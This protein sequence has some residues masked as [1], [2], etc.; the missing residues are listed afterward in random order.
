MLISAVLDPS[1]FD[2]DYFDALYRIH[3]E[4][5]LKGIERNGLLI[6]DLEDILENEISERIY[7]APTEYGQQLQ[8]YLEELLKN[9]NTRIVECPVSTNNA[10]LGTLL[11]LAYHLKID[12]KADALVVGEESLKTLKSERRFSDDIV[13]LSEYRDSDFEENRQRYEKPVGP[14]DE[15]SKSEIEDIIIRSVRFTK[16]LRFYDPYIGRGRN[17]RAFRKGIEYILSLWDEHGFFVSQQSV[18]DVE[19]FTCSAQ[20]VRVQNQ[21]RSIVQEIITPL[22]QRFSWPVNFLIKNDPRRIFHARYLETQHAIIRVERGFDLFNQ[23]DELRRN[24]FTL[25]MAEDSHL[26][27]CRE[28]PDADL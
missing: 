3:A 7:S 14:I 2:S 13:P 27:Q 26:K 1:A 22:Q 24:F 20:N 5:L 10:S 15:L 19:I 17:T 25:N 21:H 12:T 23:E 8:I 4:D 28:L 9:R 16:W 11:D 18:E 6:V